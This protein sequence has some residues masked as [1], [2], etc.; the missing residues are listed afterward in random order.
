M[1][2][3]GAGTGRQA[4]LLILGR[5]YAYVAL[6]GEAG[7]LKLSQVVCTNADRGGSEHVVAEAP[8]ESP[9]CLLRVQVTAPSGV[10]QFSYSED[11]TTFVDFGEVFSA[12]EGGWIGAKVG[13]FCLS[14]PDARNG[15]YAD[16]DWFRVE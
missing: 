15:G 10:C 7:A 2:F 8:I 4:G 5:D 12:R 16:F 6:S 13:I 3:T 1:T 14:E 9:T 11:G